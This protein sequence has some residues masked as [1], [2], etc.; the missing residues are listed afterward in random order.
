MSV[1]VGQYLR[2]T[3]PIAQSDRRVPSLRLAWPYPFGVAWE[4]L[5]HCL[6]AHDWILLM[7]Y[8]LPWPPKHQRR[9]RGR[10]E[11]AISFRKFLTS[12]AAFK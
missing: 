2:T 11:V 4:E 5:S 12:K 8:E 6:T 3:R 10:P 7:A 1:K 9:F